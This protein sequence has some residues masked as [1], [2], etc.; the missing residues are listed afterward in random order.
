MESNIDLI[1]LIQIVLSGL[2]V[3]AH[4]ARLTGFH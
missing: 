3:I 1:I 2:A 4:H